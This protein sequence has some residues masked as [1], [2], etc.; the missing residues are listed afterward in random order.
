MRPHPPACEGCP[1]DYGDD[2]LYG[3][4][5]GGFVPPDPVDEHTKLVVFGEAPGEQEEREG[6][7]FVGPSGRL[8]RG[9]L[10]RAKAF[11][12]AMSNTVLCRPPNNQ[13][14][15]F[16]IARECLRRHQPQLPAKPVLAT[17]Q[18]AIN[19][20][21]GL[22]LSPLNVRGSFLPALAGGWIVATFHPAF[23]VRGWENGDRGKAMDEL[24]PYLGLDALR[25]TQ[26]RE[27]QIP[28]ITIASPQKVR[29]EWGKALLENDR[30]N[31]G[32]LIVSVDIEGKDGVPKIVG[33]CWDVDQ[34]YVMDWSD[35]CAAV[36]AFIFATGQPL[37][38]NANYDIPELEQAGVVPPDSWEDTINVAASYDPSVRV[39][40]EPQCLSW[41]PGTTTWKGLINHEHGPDYTGGD[42]SFYRQLWEEILTKLGRGVPQSGYEWYCFYN[43]LDT[44]WA[45]RLWYGLL[46]QLGPRKR[47]YFDV[48][49]PLQKPLLVMG[50]RGVPADPAR[51]AYHQEG[52]SRV[53][54]MANTIL[55]L[56]AADM[57]G[58]GEVALREK[59]ALLES[60]REVERSQGIK[61]FTKSKELSSLRTKMKTAQKNVSGGFNADSTLQRRNLLYNWY[62]L[63]PVR[64]PKAQGPST[65]DDAIES[66]IDRLDRKDENKVRIPTIKPKRGTIEEVLQVLHAMMAAKKW[67]TWR[68]NFLTP[69]TR[70]DNEGQTWII[71]TYSQHRTDSGRLSSGV[72]N[73]DPDKGIRGKVQQLQNVP[74]K[75]RDAI[76]APPGYVMIGADYA[77][78]EWALAMW[79]AAQLNRPAG[80]HAR[81]LDEFRAGRLDPHRYLASFAFQ[82][83][84]GEITRDQR[85]LCKPYTHGYNYDGSPLTLARSVRQPGRVGEMVCAA[86]DKAFITRPWKTWTIQQA[87][88][89]HYVDTVLGWRRWFWALEPK[90]PEVLATRIQGTAADLL[91]WVAIRV[92]EEIEQQ[93]LP[94]TMLTTTHDSMLFMTPAEK[95]KEM[96]ERVKEK[97]MEMPIPWLEGR[98]WRADVKIGPNWRAVS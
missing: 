23:L 88:A 47:Y 80:H 60:E 5:G 74:K 92:L 62:G 50:Q 84:E 3:G 42:V 85:Q 96:T 48:M 12:Y 78:I 79:D 11:P 22:T 4:R 45:L 68:R 73:S 70:I 36:V 71:T 20:L 1:F 97:W 89:H 49:K 27:P 18:N 56:R 69:P 6:R 16:E 65:N 17:G 86:H 52:C 33:V 90:G 53:E 10:N 54:R 25:A 82:K 29:E 26:V 13:F 34:V 63:P 37:F 14:P 24:Y 46:E 35:G 93:D 7:G 67:A 98:S 9:V 87:K 66:L 21:T 43:G 83:P 38:H 39:G 55:R 44:G 91:K 19:A 75:L 8:L 28:R 32:K 58:E 77:G 64:D 2:F 94:I 95:A 76:V 31:P 40:L 81:L 59:V 57:L 51:L 72:D 15:G 30:C 41:V 61:K